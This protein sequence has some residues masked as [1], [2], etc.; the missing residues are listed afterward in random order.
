MRMSTEHLEQLRE[1]KRLLEHPGLAARM[2]NMIGSPIESAIG[3]LP[4]SWQKRVGVATENA[5][6]HAMRGLLQLSF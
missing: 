4:A 1:A 6:Q 3:R 2:S 5:L